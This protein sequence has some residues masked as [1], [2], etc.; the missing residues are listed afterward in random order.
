MHERSAR[1]AEL[2]PH[3]LGAGCRRFFTFGTG[4]CLDGG[5]GRYGFPESGCNTGNAWQTRNV[6]DSPLG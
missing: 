6:F 1:L 5:I 2:E 3:L 4:D